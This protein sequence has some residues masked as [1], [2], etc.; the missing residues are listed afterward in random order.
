MREQNKT[1]LS[2]IGGRIRK[3]RRDAG[4]NLTELADMCGMSAP[5]LSLIETGQRDFRL[6]SLL[7]IASALRIEATSL[8]D[9]KSATSQVSSEQKR[10]R[11]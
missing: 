3:G 1:L 11:S 8:L 7:R 10:L 4:L 2:V 6:S 5:A 9:G